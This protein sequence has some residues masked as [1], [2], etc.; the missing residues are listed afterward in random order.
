MAK[1]PR[2]KAA[3]K[4]E[5]KKKAKS[6]QDE[7]LLTGSK[8]QSL[9]NEVDQ[10]EPGNIVQDDSE[11]EQ[12]YET[13]P[14]KF[15]IQE[16]EFEERLPVKSAD[17]TL[18]RRLTKKTQK[19]EES[20]NEEEDEE[21]K[22]QAEE[23]DEDE[24]SGS[25]SEGESQLSEAERIKQAKELIAD[26]FESLNEDPEENINQLRKLRD[27]IQRSKLFKIKQLTI[28]ALVPI[29]K[30]LIPGYRIK[31]LTDAQKKE[32][33]SKDVRKLRNFEESLLNYYKT[34][35]DQLKDFVKKGRKTDEG[36]V[37][38][39]LANSAITAA[40]ELL[41]SIPHFNFQQDLIEIIVQKLSVKRTDKA[42][43]KCISTVEKIFD[44]DEEGQVSFELVRSM[45]KMIK[46]RHYKVDPR[47][48]GSLL[49]LR[50][51]T[52]LAAKADLERV[53][54][55]Q[56]P[57]IKKKDRQH[58]SKKER[59]AR[60]ERK[61][62]EEEMRIAENAVS[63][64]ERERLQGQTLKLVFVLYFNIL[65][66]RSNTLMPATLEGLAKF[67]H[68]IN[69][70]FF[71]DLLEVLREL[72][73]ERQQRVIDG[74]IEFREST[75]REALL[76]VVTAFALLSG[77]AGESMNL[78]LSFFINHFYSAL[79]ALSLNPDIEFSHKTLRLDDPLGSEQGIHQELQRKVD[80]S[81]ETE[82][83]V[84]AF[85]AIFFKQKRSN[86]GRL[87]VQAFAKR[88]SITM[89]HFPEKSTIASLKILDKM[90][91]KFHTTIPSLFSTDDRVTNGVFHMDVDE[92]E[93][94]N[95]EAATIWE[96]VLLEKHYDPKIAKAA[97]SVLHT[98]RSSHN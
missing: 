12:D 20:E 91:K 27:L 72:I 28:L 80:I 16:D 43:E 45:S 5:E 98:A 17:G 90:I 15:Q 68:L 2:G 89:L 38:F 49:H 87:R 55:P 42:F 29:Y 64:E 36:S 77:Q 76:C 75:T 94:S 46:G 58:L 62:I 95:P 92:P 61:A 81:T 23:E 9:D 86:I 93:H 59:K 60:K 3:K 73:Q 34:Y 66:E 44:A 69:A 53:E 11:E 79:F 6:Q 84:R 31:P 82:M 51:L 19:E 65:K 63:A 70:D 97:R 52:E 88:L 21:E 14:R 96:I 47:V 26:T 39:A 13:R 4:L 74:E 85:E 48:V 67:A 37:R 40:C 50:L 83:V 56:E 32:K 71:G 57:K 22:E 24:L 54:K 33:V 25:E 30:N 41:T 78:D 35:I 18:K 8:W 1:R 7:G 10:E